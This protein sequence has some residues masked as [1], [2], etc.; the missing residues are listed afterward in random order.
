[1]EKK[2]IEYIT[3][4]AGGRMSRNLS[5]G[6]VIP[7]I[8]LCAAVAVSLGFSSASAVVV[9]TGS[10][11]GQ[12]EPAKAA[13][14]KPQTTCPVMGGAID[15]QFYSDYKGKRVYFCCSACLEKFIKDPETY[16]KKLD[17]MGQKAE[18]LAVNEPGTK[19]ASSSKDTVAAVKKCPVMADSSKKKCAMAGDTSQKKCPMMNDTSKVK[20]CYTC[21]MHPGEMSKE[22]GKCPKCGMDLVFKK[23]PMDS[24]HAKGGCCKMKMQKE[25]KK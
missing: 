9:A 5:F 20:G 11:A 7:R 2:I 3:Q 12:K 13:E 6:K 24:A 1:V 25:E 16:L 8:A 14:L 19:A 18:L 15:N 23:C 4:T 21:P 10:G 22:P 17:K